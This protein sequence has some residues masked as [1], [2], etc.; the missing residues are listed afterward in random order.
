MGKDF[1]WLC[2]EFPRGFAAAAHIQW[3]GGN[4]GGSALSPQRCPPGGD[5]ALQPQGL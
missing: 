5:A 3:F 2:A 1:T 4:F